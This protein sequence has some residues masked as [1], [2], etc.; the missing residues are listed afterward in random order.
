MLRLISFIK[1]LRSKVDFK[2]KIKVY[3]VE[4]YVSYY[5]NIKNSKYFVDTSYETRAAYQ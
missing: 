4:S 1:I 3:E 2:T 5:Y